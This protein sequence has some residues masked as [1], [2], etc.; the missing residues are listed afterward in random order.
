[1]TKGEV[2]MA[3]YRPSSF[4]WVFVGQEKVQVNKNV[5]KELLK[6]IFYHLSWTSLVNKVF[7]KIM[8]K[9]LFH[10]VQKV[11]YQEG[12]KGPSCPLI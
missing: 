4:L 2:K 10:V 3:W 12:K 5:E 8:S 11:Q 6:E 7:M 9:N 1:M